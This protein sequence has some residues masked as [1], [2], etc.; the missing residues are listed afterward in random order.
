MRI[1]QL[2][3]LAVIS[4][5]VCTQTN[6]ATVR[7]L[8]TK[9]VH[10]ADLNDVLPCNISLSGPIEK[11][12]ARKLRSA[13]NDGKFH[14]EGPYAKLCLDSRGGLYSEA[15]VLAEF[16]LNNFVST[17][18]PDGAECYSACAIVF[19]AGLE[20]QEEGGR[21]VARSLHVGGKL[22]FHAPFISLEQ[23]PDARYGKQD[24]FKTYQAAVRGIQKLVK[25]GRG[26]GPDLKIVPKGLLG[27]MLAIDPD[28]FYVIDTVYRALRFEI[29][30]FGYRPVRQIS[31][32]TLCN[33]CR[34]FFSGRYGE[35]EDLMRSGFCKGTN[36]KPIK[37]RKGRE[38][39]FY[40]F[41]EGLS[42]IVKADAPYGGP[43]E[44]WILP[45]LDSADVSHDDM[46]RQF[47]LLMNSDLYLDSKTK[48]QDLRK[49]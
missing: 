43:L 5:S 35:D 45:E 42:C 38:L 14:S 33:A 34:N 23:L 29:D 19:M 27:E 26:I 7:V 9:A 37:M 49:R 18:V 30:L 25:L 22:G 17:V 15:L 47:R 13:F 21:G 28:N 39:S 16:L 12:D 20:R 11:G 48:L 46:R 10:K 44:W 6:A 3:I 32:R 24:V 41:G 8:K 4:I 1:I 31:S 40:F 2:L 36:S